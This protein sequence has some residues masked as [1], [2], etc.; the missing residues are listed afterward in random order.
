MGP[1]AVANQCVVGALATWAQMHTGDPRWNHPPALFGNAI[2]LFGV[3]RA[4]GFADSSQPAPGEMVVY[5]TIPLPRPE[6]VAVPPGCEGRRGRSGHLVCGGGCDALFRRSLDRVEHPGSDGQVSDGNELRSGASPEAGELDQ[7]RAFNAALER[8]LAQAPPFEAADPGQL[9]AAAYEGRG[10]MPPPEFLPQARD[11]TVPGRG[12]DIRLR[13]LRPEAHPAVG[14]Y[15]HLHGGGWVL[16]GC[17]LQDPPLFELA[18]ATGLVAVSVAYRLAPEHPYPAAPD[19][20]EDAAL[21]VLEHGPAELD[22]P[23]VFAIGG[24]SAGANLGVVTLLRLRDRHHLDHAFQA[25][26]LLYGCYDVSMTP[27]QRLWGDRRLPLTTSSI[28]WFADQYTPGLGAEERRAPDVSPL[29]AP[30]QDMPPALFSVGQLDP[31]LDDTLFIAARW[32]AAGREAELH[33]YPECPHGFARFPLA[34]ASRCNRAEHAFLNR[35]LQ[36]HEGGEMTDPSVVATECL[37][38]WTIGDF[39]RARALIADDITFAGPFGTAT[40]ADAYMSG[41][42]R[43]HQRGV[44]SAEIH[45]VFHDADEVCIFYDLCTRTGTGV[46]PSAAWYRIGPDG[47]ISSVRV[48][49]DPRPLT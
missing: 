3:A 37:R 32:R 21:W 42:Q 20:C 49:F 45:K 43:F 8:R 13:V 1:S 34:A 33:V 24:E 47:R 38:S 15:L 4:Q 31:L 36:G 19:D 39:D 2:D 46:V 12:G 48:L 18:Q 11:L 27:S 40:G 14:I 25:A 22:A 41:L 35:R 26:A 6:L 30:L 29:Y 7:L 9:R 23:G 44:L 10:T 16:G 17:D 28:S 5:G